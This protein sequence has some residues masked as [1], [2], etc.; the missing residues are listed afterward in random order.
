MFIIKF[1]SDYLHLS[2]QP[3]YVLIIG[4]FILGFIISKTKKFETLFYGL[5]ILAIVVSIYN[6]QIQDIQYQ[7]P[8]VQPQMVIPTVLILF[9]I[10]L[11][12][13]FARRG[14]G[15]LKYIILSTLITSLFS[16]SYIYTFLNPTSQISQIT[17]KFLPGLNLENAKLITQNANTSLTNTKD[18]VS[19][20]INHFRKTDS[21]EIDYGKVSDKLPTKSL[22]DSVM[23]SDVIK[24]LSNTENI[25]WNNVGSYVIN[26]N[27]TDLN[28]DVSSAPYA[29]TSKINSNGQAGVANALL[30]KNTRQ[31]KDRSQTYSNGKANDRQ[32]KPRGWKQLKLSSGSYLYQRG[33]LLAYALIGNI[34]GFD[35]S[36]AN[37]ENIIT[38]TAYANAVSATNSAQNYYEGIIRKALDQN[39]VVRYRVTPIYAHKTDSVAVGT[40]LE[41]KSKDGSI[42][43]NVFVPNVQPGV[44]ID[45]SNGQAKEK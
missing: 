29:S 44:S 11:T 40:H 41:A 7:V 22:S 34:K 25:I 1:I 10:G 30:N 12:I 42:Q 5:G 16:G 20:T 4:L 33:H 2:E 26:N 27:V 14:A 32:I 39:K 3:T 15:F 31:Y 43:F 19:N 6:N 24:N 21:T 13:H 45:Y 37:A 18:T 28:A 8:W 9:G 36:E 35:A 23:S 17:S 38:Q